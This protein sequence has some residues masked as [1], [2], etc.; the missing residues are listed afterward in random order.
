MTWRKAIARGRAWPHP[1]AQLG[2]A[3]A[4]YGLLRLPS[5][6][7]PHWYTDEAS[8]VGVGR[9]LLRGQVLY[10]QTWNNKPPLQ[11]WTV[12]FEVRLFGSSEAGLH[13][14][15]L[16]SGALAI[17][18]V[19]WAAWKLLSPRRAMVAALLAAVALG[20]PVLDA[21][22]AIPE[23][24]LIAPLAWAGAL[25]VVNLAPNALQPVA[26]TRWALLAG[27]L[28]A[29]AIAYQQTAVAEF[30]AF[31]L[32]LVLSP[33]TRWRHVLLYAGTVAV[34]TAGWVA[35]AMSQAGAG[36]VG[37]ALVGFYI[38]YTQ[39]VFPSTGGGI[40]LHLAEIG[41]ATVLLAVGG[42]LSRRLGAA[43]WVII[44]WAG[45]SLMVP[46][47]SRQPYA[48]YLTPA[49]APLSLLAASLPLPRRASRPT[50]AGLLRLS[51]QVAGL[52][53]AAAMASVAGLDWVPEA[54]PSPLLNTSRTLAMYYGG[55][56][57]AAINQE[58]RKGWAAKFDSRVGADEE[59]ADWLESQGLSGSSA[60]VWSSDAWLYALA[61]LDEAVPTP[62]IYNDE[63]L[64]GINGPV[65]DHVDASNPT[66]IIVSEDA[67]EQF[68]E[69][70][71]LLDGS[72][73]KRLF[74]SA[75]DSVWVRGDV[76]AALG[77]PP[78]TIER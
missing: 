77:T 4:L 9:A 35:L 61:D 49:V 12:A 60:V 33:R 5:F 40:A 58:Q 7:E 68:P 14:L 17:G 66:L 48:H 37:F 3:F 47:L 43:R 38:A 55:A 22:L 24:L 51:P 11:S 71:R 27:A 78:G 52:A 70:S 25:I 76:V 72:R 74:E 44:L 26:S 16:V 64:F 28:T 31:V 36:N 32:V 19:A 45:A 30:C 46:A 21:E 34:I 23:S 63:V 18:A 62:P 54:A 10:A 65:A 6:M 53:I 50:G 73:Y 2:P 20:L 41:V 39:S 15:T 13:L 56:V 57:G 42:C 8:Y 59:V 69:V 75:P 67:L 29:A 1:L